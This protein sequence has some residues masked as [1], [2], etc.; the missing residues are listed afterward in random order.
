MLRLAARILVP[1]LFLA[2]IGCG[3]T[4]PYA[5]ILDLTELAQD[6][7][8]YHGLPPNERL[9]GETAQQAAWD[10]FIEAHFDPWIRTSAKHTAEEV[11]WGLSSY[12]GKELF[13]ENTLPR[14][15]GW[16]DR[17]RAA[18]RTKDYPSLHRRAVT[19]VN[20]HMRVLPTLHPAFQDFRKA[21][22]G[23]PFDYM[24]NSLVLA[25]TPLLATHVSADR[26]WVLVESR[27]AYGWVRATDIGWVD[28]GFVATYRTN[29]YAAVTRDRVPVVDRDG[30]YCFTAQVGAILPVA[31]T[32]DDGR[33]T[34]LVP[35]RDDR[36]NAVIHRA[37]LAEATARPAPVPATP[38]DFARVANE[39]MG[40][41]YGWGGL[42]ENRDCSAMTMD[43][44]AAFGILLPRN[45]SKQIE[46][47]TRVSLE[48]LNRDEKK[49]AIIEHSTPFLTLVR[50]PGHIMLYVGS[51]EGDPIVLHATWGVK[52]E[53]GDGLG[54]KVIGATV[55]TTLE[56][57]LE[58]DDLARHG[59]VLLDSVLAV[60]TLP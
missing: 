4:N 40:R 2:L 17:M 21:G 35:V 43:L 48:G 29:V 19:V 54:R 20:A 36:G 52:T 34:T 59:G 55:I 45:S 38:H 1:L 14:D 41:Q 42:F 22:E 7:G 44:M 46:T 25:G 58:L 60:T 37:D 57:G 50:K 9:L 26:A 11:F 47:G 24:Q 18:S 31:E 32:A 27:F 6:A 33:M 30:Q 5:P 28:D 16:L 13:G 15:P 39:M 51:R 53:T 56:P 3:T 10:R 12:A 8:A 49:R 23:F